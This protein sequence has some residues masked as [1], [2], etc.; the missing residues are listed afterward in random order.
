ML[1]FG[2]KPKVA[3]VHPAHIFADDLERV[4]RA[5]KSRHVH[6]N[7]IA[8]KLEEHAQAVRRIAAMSYEP[9]RMHSGNI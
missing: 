8:S 9:R 5:A 3:D 7:V 6:A 1:G 2:N 4:I